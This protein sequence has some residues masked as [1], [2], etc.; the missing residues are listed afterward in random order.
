MFYIRSKSIFLHQNYLG[1]LKL[2]KQKKFWKFSNFFFWTVYRVRGAMVGGNFSPIGEYSSTVKNRQKWASAH[3]R[4][5]LKGL[6]CFYLNF[7]SMNF[8]FI[9]QMGQMLLAPVGGGGGYRQPYGIFLT[10]C[11][12]KCLTNS[13]KG[14]DTFCKQYIFFRGLPIPSYLLPE[15]IDY[16]LE[17]LARGIV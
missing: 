16:P 2:S 5:G 9:T 1:V 13:S 15:G 8:I 4:V 6:I 7:I 12:G 3:R 14:I 11:I 17:Q 10:V